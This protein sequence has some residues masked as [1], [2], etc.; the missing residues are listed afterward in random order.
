M[1]HQLCIDWQS[2]W[3]GAFFNW[4]L[5]WGEN[6]TL[7]RSQLKND[8]W[9]GVN[10]TC[11]ANHVF[12]IYMPK[13]VWFIMPL[14]SSVIDCLGQLVHTL[15]QNRLVFVR[16]FRQK[17]WYTGICAPRNWCPG[18]L[19]PYRVNS[20]LNRSYP[21]AKSASSHPNFPP[22]TQIYQY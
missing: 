18:Q 3:R 17:L 6:F 13:N 9:E 7:R 14:A 22:K 4:Y 12:H 19:V 11:Q 10:E 1:C 5:H 15:P 21:P 20:A 16:I 2:K 8:T